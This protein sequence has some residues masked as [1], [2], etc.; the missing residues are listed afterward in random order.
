VIFGFYS[1][2]VGASGLLGRVGV[3]QGYLFL[4][5]WR[6]MGKHYYI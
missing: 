1:S 2:F 3:T 4:S 5:F 6:N